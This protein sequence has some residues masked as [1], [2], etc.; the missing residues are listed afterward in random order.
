MELEEFYTRADLIPRYELE[1]LQTITIEKGEIFIPLERQEKIKIYYILEGTV[2]CFSISA[3]GRTFIVD[4]LAEG[5]FIGKFSQMRSKNFNCGVRA[6]TNL[7]LLDFT[8]K[9]EYFFKK[10]PDFYIYFLHRTTDR[11]YEMYRRSMI[12]SQFAYEEVF[13]YWLLKLMD[14]NGVVANLGTAFDS[15]GISE[16]HA[17]NLMNDFKEKK[18]ILNR[19]G[20]RNLLILDKKGLYELAENVLDFMDDL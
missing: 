19:R 7:V 16:R 1:K 9:A 12:N 20:K 17:Y 3:A 14:K 10:Y 15:M 5:E 2:E 18:Y 6:V 13:A 11:L 4:N 8:N